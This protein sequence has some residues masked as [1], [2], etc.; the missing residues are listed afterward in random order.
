MTWR[1]HRVLMFDKT[2]AAL[3]GTVPIRAPMGWG[4]THDGEQ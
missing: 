2:N 4:L 3:A 1:E